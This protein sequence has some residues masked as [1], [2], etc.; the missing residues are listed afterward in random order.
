MKKV[1]ALATLFLVGSLIFAAS[2]KNNTYQKL[3]DEYTKKAQNALDAGEYVLA[4]EYA[5]KAE[6][7]AR[8]SE[9]FV[10]KMLAKSD[11]D[12]IMKQAA[13][14]LEYAKSV[15][16]ERNF[17]MAYSSAQKSYASAQESYG[18]ED[19]A[20][21]T[22]YA[23]Q[24]LEALADIKEITPLPEYYVVRPWAETKDCYW[25]ISGRPYVYDNPLL[26]ENLYQA[27]KSNMPRPNDP[28][29]ILPG[30]KMKIPSITGEYREGVYNPSKKY[31]P[32]SA[33]R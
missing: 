23:K 1:I 25:N 21:A 4:E 8:L 2:Y 14:K 28:N 13:K 19:Y 15:N 11:C 3:A 20:T 17:P 31:D 7:N 32:Y 29:L 33:N 24:V 5:A 30:M 9:E 18:N 6:E 27:N 26:W 22:A 10:K 12:T 16:A